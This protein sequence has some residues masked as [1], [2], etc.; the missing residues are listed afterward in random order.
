M[1]S[2]KTL[3]GAFLLAAVAHA[4]VSTDGTCG[5]TQGYTCLGSAFGNCCSQWGW[6]GSSTGH[7]GTG[8][9]P[10][11]GSCDNG[12][13]PSTLQTS[14]TVRPSSTR[15]SSSTP[16]PTPTTKV[17]TDGSCGAA[18]GSTCSGSAFGRCCS[19]HGWC[20]DTSVY[21]STG[22]QSGFGNC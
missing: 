18:N 2:F 3:A 13:P 8:C 11:F 6:C 7:C 22:C 9:N 5:G 14:T 19:Q 10:A 16:P 17:T 4:A 1:K 15:T 21:C 20:G 12:P